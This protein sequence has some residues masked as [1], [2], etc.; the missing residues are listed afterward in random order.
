MARIKQR[1]AVRRGAYHIFFFCPTLLGRTRITSM[2]AAEPILKRALYLTVRR[3]W[4]AYPPVLLFLSLAV[5]VVT[6]SKT[7]QEKY[8]D[9]GMRMM[10][11]MPTFLYSLSGHT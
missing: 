5:L 8:G 7:S 4:L 10:P 3:E 2:W 11:T 1:H 6:M 9:V